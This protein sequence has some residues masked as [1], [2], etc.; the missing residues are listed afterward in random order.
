[1][2]GINQYK[3]S[4]VHSGR[5]DLP[6]RTYTIVKH[7]SK[8]YSLTTNNP[9]HSQAMYLGILLPGKSARNESNY[10]K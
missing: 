10:T 7:F 9:H 4:I 1:M 2:K 3:E 5:D 8:Q 6:G